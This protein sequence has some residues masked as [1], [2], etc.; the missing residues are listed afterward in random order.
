MK[1][2][3]GKRIARLR[4]EKGMTQLDLAERMGVTDKAVS[5]WE[6]DLSCPDISTLPNLAQTLGISMEELMQTQKESPIQLPT[7]IRTIA[8]TALKGV[9]MAMGIA[10]AVLSVLGEL[11]LQSGMTMLGIGLACVA[12]SLLSETK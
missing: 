5:K 10:V 3:L 8:D 12:I 7:Q 11:E 1:E 6:R 9:A 2:T 4:R